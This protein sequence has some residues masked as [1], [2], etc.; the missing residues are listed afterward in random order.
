MNV[1]FIFGNGFD[2]NLGMKTRYVDFYKK[3]PIV[4]SNVP[5][6]CGALDNFKGKK[7]WDFVMS[8][9]WESIKYNNSQRQAPFLSPN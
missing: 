8:K 4:I 2:I 6:Y 9:G 3:N 7:N 5:E 1:S